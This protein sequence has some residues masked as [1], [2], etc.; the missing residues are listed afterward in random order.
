MPDNTP[1]GRVFATDRDNLEDIVYNGIDSTP[2]L[3]NPVNGAVVRAFG[4]TL[5]YE[6]R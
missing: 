1:I 5:D 4:E 3:V 6:T 2:F